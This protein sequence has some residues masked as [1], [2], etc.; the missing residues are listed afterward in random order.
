MIRLVFLFLSILNIA[1]AAR[2]QAAELSPEDFAYGMT[3]TTPAPAT[4]YR[5]AI[6]L[7]VYKKAVHED[8]RDL[9]VFNAQGEVVPYE[10]MPPPATPVEQPP[11]VSLPLF[12]LHGNS[13]VTFD[14][15][16]VTIQSLGTAV[17]VEAAGPAS[18]PNV[19]TGYILD[20]RTLSFPLSVLRLQWQENAPEFSGTIRVDSSDDLESWQ[21]ARGDAQVVNLLNGNA[22]LL[23][24]SVDIATPTK[25]KFW[26]LT[27]VGLTAP[28][29]ISSVT[30]YPTEV[31]RAERSSLTVTGTPV[32]DKHQEFSFDLGARLPVNQINIELPESN[33]V[34]KIQLLSRARPSDPWRPITPGDFYRIRSESSERFN[35]SI[36]IATNSD[37]YWLARPEQPDASPGGAPKLEATWATEDVVFL[38]RG[39]GPFTLAYGNGGAGAETATLNS[40]LSGV[41]VLRAGLEESHSL[42]GEGRLA[43]PA[44]AVPWKMTILWVVL[45]IGVLLLAWMSYRLSRELGRAKA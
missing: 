4:A 45:A 5:V 3:I 20:A 9:R 27:W 34:S 36:A 29:E 37:R 26:R 23:R 11:G 19:I 13:R 14:G 31:R 7:E 17:N 28:F 42:G 39:S 24:G 16:H 21:P 38:A 22:Q 6:P 33:S 32:G 8:L 35:E 15:M 41:T 30:A 1:W 10:L 2:A 25:A 12:P 18:T 44:R 40:L 43:A